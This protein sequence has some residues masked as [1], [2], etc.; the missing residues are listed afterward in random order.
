MHVPE[1][2]HESDERNNELYFFQ[3]ESNFKNHN[4]YEGKVF[5]NIVDLDK[6]CDMSS[7]VVLEE[8]IP[9]LYKVPV[10][11]SFELTGIVRELTLESFHLNVTTTTSLK[12]LTKV[13]LLVDNQLIF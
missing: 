10:K 9:N 13:P 11:E 8:F 1:F 5:M 2:L 12:K 4:L 6:A 7:S 3:A